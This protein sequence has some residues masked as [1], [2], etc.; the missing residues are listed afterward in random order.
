MLLV[1]LLQRFNVYSKGHLSYG[2]DIHDPEIVG[3]Y[4]VSHFLEDHQHFND[5]EGSS[6]FCNTPCHTN[7]SSSLA[8]MYD[9]IWILQFHLKLYEKIEI[10]GHEM[11]GREYNTLHTVCV[12]SDVDNN[13]HQFWN[14]LEN[15]T[16][17]PTIYL[18]QWFPNDLTWL[19]FSSRRSSSLHPLFFVFMKLI[20]LVFIL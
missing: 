3:P 6:H 14:S 13:F 4:M 12:K 8:E 18:F 19:L 5:C 2:I 16:Q 17:W 11:L 1:V 10:E 15:T 9:G 7:H 20:F